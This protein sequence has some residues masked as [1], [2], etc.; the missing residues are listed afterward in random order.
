[1]TYKG[2]R[3]TSAAGSHNLDCSWNDDVLE[4]WQILRTLSPKLF[5]DIWQN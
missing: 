5:E 3:S 4:D 1:M 2:V